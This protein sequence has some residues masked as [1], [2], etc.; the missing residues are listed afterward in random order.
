MDSRHNIV[1][2][3]LPEEDSDAKFTLESLTC[4]L[5][6]EGYQNP[7]STING[8][9]YERKSVE[10]WIEKKG[11]DPIEGAHHNK[12]DLRPNH[13][14]KAIHDEYRKKVIP[15]L[16]ELQ[17]ART[18]LRQLLEES[19]KEREQAKRNQAILELQL[20]ETHQKL[21]EALEELAS[22]KKQE[23][24]IATP[25]SST[26]LPFETISSSALSFSLF[27]NKDATTGGNPSPKKEENRKSPVSVTK[28]LSSNQD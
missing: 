5:T 21:K 18:L 1:I 17:T 13:A 12:A 15:Q 20:T 23:E 25:R 26:P 28:S 16:K 22:F 10:D 11:T 3:D 19:N 6:H 7:V 27:L 9:T 4:P 8:H 14:V 24:T 2:E